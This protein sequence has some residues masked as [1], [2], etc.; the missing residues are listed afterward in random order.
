MTVV[1]LLE[2]PTHTMASTDHLLGLSAGTARRWIDG[3]QRKGVAYPPVVRLRR[4]GD[5]TV[6]WG[7]FVECRMLSGYRDRGVPMVRMRPA[8]DLL[9]E[10]LG[11]PYPLAT[12]KP[13]V[14]DR[15]LVL[16]AQVESGLD[17]KLYL[18]VVRNDQLVLNDPANSFF[19]EVEW[20][21]EVA[22]A[23]APLGIDNV[24]RIDPQRGF[25]EPVV[26]NVRTSVLAELADAGHSVAELAEWYELAPDDV[27]A[28]VTYEAQRVA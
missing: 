8:I 19:E 13:Y 2:R 3:Y 17:Q 26:R 9:R 1:D 25:G 6:T 23:V 11:T 5:D 28:A 24:V 10:R 14:A 27:R 21:D 7:E 16:R 18:V 22:Q 12:S 20:A 4:T 15:D